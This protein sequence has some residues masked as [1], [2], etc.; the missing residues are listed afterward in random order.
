M[1][2][3][4]DCWLRDGQRRKWAKLQGT[5][6]PKPDWKFVGRD[7]T[8]ARVQ[9]EG[10]TFGLFRYG[11]GWTARMGKLI[12]DIRSSLLDDPAAKLAILGT[13]IAYESIIASMKTG[14]PAISIG[15]R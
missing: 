6:C 15:G 7:G 10:S 11:Y 13:V 2:W 1:D 3:N 12:I 9:T 5:K 4:Q 14:G 8:L